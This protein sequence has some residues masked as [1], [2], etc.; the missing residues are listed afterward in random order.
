MSLFCY[1]V[2]SVLSSY[3]I[4]LLRKGE[5]LLYLI[6]IWCHVSV[7]VLCLLLILLCV[8]LHCVTF[9]GHTP[10]FSE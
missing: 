8:G 3:A 4:V 1:A 6:N 7:S 2:L 9:P 5:L 10:L